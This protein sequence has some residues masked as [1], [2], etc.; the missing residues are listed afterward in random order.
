MRLE[1]CAI[2]SVLK[3]PIYGAQLC[4]VKWKITDREYQNCEIITPKWYNYLPKVNDVVVICE[5]HNSEMVVLGVLEPFDYSLEVW[6]CQMHGGDNVQEGQTGVYNKKAHLKIN[7]D[8]E[9]QIRQWTTDTAWGVFKPT[10]KISMTKDD[11]LYIQ[12]WAY[13]WDSFKALQNVVFG[14][15]WNILI[16]TQD[17]N[18]AVQASITISPVGEVSID[19]KWKMNITSDDDIT[20]KS[21]TKVQV[22]APLLE[23]L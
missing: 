19:T 5:L 11:L 14:S 17:L 3:D 2:T 23:V 18:G 20:L 10:K 16:S 12:R 8:G 9:I 7:K 21:S 6:E 4:H 15:S 13:V 22:D 1:Y